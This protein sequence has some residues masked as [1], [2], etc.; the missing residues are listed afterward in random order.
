MHVAIVFRLYPNQTQEILFKQTIGCCRFI[1]NFYLDFKIKEYQRFLKW[2]KAN[3]KKPKSAF[4]WKKRPTEAELK[5]KYPWLRDPDSATVIQSRRDLENAFK[6]FFNGVSK[7]PQFH[8]KGGKESFRCTQTIYVDPPNQSIRIGK[9]GWIKARG[10]FHKIIGKIKN[11]TVRLLAGRWYA[12]VLQEIPSEQYY[13]PL[14]HKYDSVGIDLGVTHPLTL[15]SGSSHK[16]VGHVTQDSLKKKE[17]KRKRYQRQLAR[18]QKGSKNRAKAKLKVARAFQKERNIRKDFVE[19]TSHLLTSMFR[20]L[21]FEDLSLKNM[22]KKGTGKHGLNRELLRMGLSYIVGRCRVKA[23]QRG[24]EVVLVNSR[25][26]S[27]ICSA[28]GNKDR[29]SRKNQARYECARCGFI[30]NADINAARNILQR[31]LNQTQMH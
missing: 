13:A 15:V 23:S 20:V 16:H 17:L 26:T 12:S 2:Q 19:K 8:K 7:R 29:D 31:G 28:C 1:Y 25:H 4:Q 14:N 27:Q 6:R 10:S 30:L 11:I 9:N 24:G 3:P 21:V 18:K 5:K 22:T